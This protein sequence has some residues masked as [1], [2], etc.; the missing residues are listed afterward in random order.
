MGAGSARHSSQETSAALL[1]VVRRLAKELHAQRTH[2]APATLDSALDRDLG[3]DSL[4][5]VELMARIEHAF[6]V[7]LSDQLLASAE[8]PRDLLRA[9]LGAHTARRPA[10][11]LRHRKRP[12]ARPGRRGPSPRCSTGTC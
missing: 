3:F 1:E 7:I 8:T 9:V 11:A 4:S 12:T 5:R 10:A 6:G 2:T